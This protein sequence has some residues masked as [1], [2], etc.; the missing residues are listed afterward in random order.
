MTSL[1]ATLSPDFSARSTADLL[2]QLG[3]LVTTENQ[4]RSR[5]NLLR[6]ERC[7]V[8]L[9]LRRRVKEEQR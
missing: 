8:A 5:A 2:V 7:A 1:D 3:H 6:A 9:E 4:H